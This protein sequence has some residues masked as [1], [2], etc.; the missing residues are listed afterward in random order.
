MGLLTPKQKLVISEFSQVLVHES[1]QYDQ[2]KS[3]DDDQGK[4]QDKAKEYA[5]KKIVRSK[6]KTDQRLLNMVLV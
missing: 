2:L 6:D 4:V 3:S 5:L 1:S